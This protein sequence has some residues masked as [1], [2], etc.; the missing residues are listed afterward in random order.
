[1]RWKISSRSLAAR[2]RDHQ[3]LLRVS[4]SRCRRFFKV[5]LFRTGKSCRYNIQIRSWY[6]YSWCWN[7][8]KYI[9][10]IGL[11]HPNLY[12]HCSSTFN[13]KFLL[14]WKSTQP[15]KSEKQLVCQT[16]YLGYRDHPEVSDQ[17]LPA[18]CFLHMF[19]TCKKKRNITVRT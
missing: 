4:F 16:V 1:M 2:D 5:G 7:D 8:Q 13:A 10:P 12:T 9:S 17:W 3:G 6:Y 15:W 14:F 18:C 11:Y 19:D